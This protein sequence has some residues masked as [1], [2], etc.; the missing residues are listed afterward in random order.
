MFHTRSTFIKAI[1]PIEM[2]VVDFSGI[3]VAAKEY[4]WKW[5]QL[6]V[7]LQF[8]ISVIV[9]LCVICRSDLRGRKLK[10]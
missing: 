1:Q 2:P 6:V 9:A 8:V 5:P 10:F 3:R 4:G 7:L